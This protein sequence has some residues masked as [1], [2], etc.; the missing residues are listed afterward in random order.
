[1]NN[2]EGIQVDFS[3]LSDWMS[4]STQQDYQNLISRYQKFPLLANNVMETMREGLR[5]KLTNHAVTM[6]SHKL[7]QT[8]L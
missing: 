3:R 8:N 7:S 4:V 5:R 2:I 1:M 6:V